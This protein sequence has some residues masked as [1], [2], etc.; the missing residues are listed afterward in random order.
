MKI[1][2]MRTTQLKTYVGAK[3][4]GCGSDGPHLIEVVISVN[5]G[6]EG[7]ACDVYDYCD[8]CFDDR[9]PALVAAGSR[10]PIVT[11]VEAPE[12][13]GQT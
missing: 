11:G 9:I 10:A 7:G 8:D 6:E 12:Q 13:D 4:D 1:Y 5:E 2:E 3:C